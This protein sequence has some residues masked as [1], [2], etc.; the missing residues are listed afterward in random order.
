MVRALAWGSRS[1]WRK[2][3]GAQL[4]CYTS[5]DIKSSP[6]LNPFSVTLCR[7]LQLRS[8]SH[9]FVL[10]LGVGMLCPVSKYPYAPTGTRLLLLQLSWIQRGFTRR[11][12]RPRIKIG[13][14]LLGLCQVSP[15]PCAT[16]ED[17]QQGRMR[18]AL[19][20]VLA[21]FPKLSSEH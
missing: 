5:S 1:A 16:E 3:H 9:I 18:M 8:L 12:S 2:I 17:A 20:V 7:A 15:E 6:Y 4:L 10:P 11:K 19:Q 13:H 21:A 14:R